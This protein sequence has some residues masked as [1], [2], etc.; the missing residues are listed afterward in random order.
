[1]PLSPVFVGVVQHDVSVGEHGMHS[2]EG[3]ALRPEMEGV[4]AGRRTSKAAARLEVM[5]RSSV[6]AGV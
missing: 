1:V 5:I 2:G 6:A 3:R 4:L